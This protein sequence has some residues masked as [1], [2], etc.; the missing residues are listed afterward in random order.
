MSPQPK[1]EIQT[2]THASRTIQ[3]RCLPTF[4]VR[5]EAD[6]ECAKAC[7]FNFGRC[8]MEW[9]HPAGSMPWDPR[10]RDGDVYGFVRMAN[11][12]V[13]ARETVQ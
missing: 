2:E 7:D 11:G 1:P 8:L 13:F 12:A 6:G 10:C 9:R 4:L 5:R 3:E